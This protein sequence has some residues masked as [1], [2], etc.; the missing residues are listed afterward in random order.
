MKELQ[1]ILGTEI[2]IEVRGIL[3]LCEF[4][5]YNLTLKVSNEIFFVS[6][7]AALEAYGNIPNPES[8]IV[9]GSTFNILI[10]NLLEL[11]KRMKNKEWL[12]EL[13]ACL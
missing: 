12:E 8:Q 1:T 3:Y 4:D 9:T 10:T 2:P 5:R 13:D 7:W 11:H 6:V